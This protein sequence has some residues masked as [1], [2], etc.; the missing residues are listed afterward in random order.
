MPAASPDTFNSGSTFIRTADDSSAASG[1]V[2]A[3]CS[4]PHITCVGYN[5]K[6]DFLNKRL[7]GC[8]RWQLKRRHEQHDGLLTTLY[9]DLQ[10]TQPDHLVI[11]G[12][13]THLS[14]PAEFAS[15]RDWLQTMGAPEQITVIPGNHDQYVRTEWQ[16]SFAFW[17]PYMQSDTSP[18]QTAEAATSLEEL[19]PT[20]RIRRDIA[21]IGTSTARPSALHLATGTIGKSQLAKLEMILQQLDGQQLFRILLI[22]HPPI[23]GVVSWRRSLTDASALA[24]IDRTLRGRAGPL[25]PRPQNSP[26]LSPRAG[27][28]DPRHGGAIGIIPGAHRRTTRPLF[29]V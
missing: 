18:L 8:L 26:G 21:L 1:Y 11:T 27:G 16:Q 25:R 15:A 9:Q 3:H 20:L 14:L 12:D 23:S 28:A 7:V 13:M 5:R 17:L 4:D 24:G 2:V 22:H 6:R 10:R 19:F 29:P